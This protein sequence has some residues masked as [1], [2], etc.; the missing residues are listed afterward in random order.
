MRIGAISDTHGLLRPQ[1]LAALTGCDPIIHAGDVGSPDVLAR[2]GTLASVHAVRGNVDHG[3]WS[4]N[5]PVTR[6]IKIDG[7]R[8]YVL[9][10]LDEL[11]PQTGDISEI[12]VV[13]AAQAIG[14]D[15]GYSPMGL[16]AF[17][18]LETQ[19]DPARPMLVVMA[20]D[21][22]N[23]WGGGYSYYMEAVPN[24][25]NS[26]QGAGY[27]ATV[28]EEYLADHPVPS[29][30]VVHVEDGAW[31]NADG[32]FRHIVMCSINHDWI[33]RRQSGASHIRQR[34]RI[35]TAIKKSDMRF[36]VLVKNH[37]IQANST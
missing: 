31:V 8:I 6:R 14:W 12:I 30:E 5:L 1:A 10:I 17:D 25:V 24:F 3:A 26:A 18:T 19:N 4:A 27:H 29:D 34:R 35:G 33:P 16:D 23:A 13:P 9:H 7:F 37:I 28:V 11:D 21:G 22:D 2:L 15:N 36:I 32:D 20:H